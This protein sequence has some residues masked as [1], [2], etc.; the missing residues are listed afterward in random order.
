[1]KFI[2]AIGLSVISKELINHFIFGMA[3]NELRNK[4]DNDRKQWLIAHNAIILK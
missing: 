1:M 4:A 2:I 3:L